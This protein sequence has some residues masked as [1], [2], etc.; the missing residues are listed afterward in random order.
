MK[1]CE[2]CGASLAGRSKRA[3]F[4][5]GTCRVRYGRGHRAEAVVVELPS[6]RAGAEEPAESEATLDSIAEELQRTLHDRATPATAKA[7]LAR[8]LRA[9]LAAI[10]ASRPPARDGVDELFERRNRGA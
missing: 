4:C 7:A 2:A 1:R 9:T 3:R 5:N 8:E 6:A 10:A